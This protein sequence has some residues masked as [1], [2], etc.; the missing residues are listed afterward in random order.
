MILEKI[1]K[2]CFNYLW[3]GSGEYMG[4]HLTN[5]KSIS[6]PKKWGAWGLKD[7]H[8]FG[9]SLAARSI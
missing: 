6:L 3:R 5:W 8:F 9:K 1:W 7:V 4:L 2:L